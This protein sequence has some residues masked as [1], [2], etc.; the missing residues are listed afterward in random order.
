MLMMLVAD[1]PT[2]FGVA[3]INGLLFVA[4]DVMLLTSDLITTLQLV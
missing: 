2:A 4:S 3:V 1:S